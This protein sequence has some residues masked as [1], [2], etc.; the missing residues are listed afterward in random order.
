MVQKLGFQHCL[1][2]CRHRMTLHSV[3][4]MQRP[5][6]S[7]ES[8]TAMNLFYC[9]SVT[10]IINQCS[11]RKEALPHCTKNFPQTVDRATFAKINFSAK[12]HSK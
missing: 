11:M 12:G 1:N 7:E 10:Q 8:L 9:T 4:Q 3:S 6:Q 2:L 5:K